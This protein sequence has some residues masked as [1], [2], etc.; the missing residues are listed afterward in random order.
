[1]RRLMLLPVGR[2]VEGVVS[3]EACRIERG[4]K[5]TLAV[6][7]AGGMAPL[8]R[9]KRSLKRVTLFETEAS[10]ILPA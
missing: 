6:V 5:V 3:S 10:E 4:V 2:V 9:M 8:A 7:T 1:M